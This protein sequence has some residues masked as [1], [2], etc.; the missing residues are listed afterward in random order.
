MRLVPESVKVALNRMRECSREYA[1]VAGR[2]GKGI[3]VM[4]PLCLVRTEA[5]LQAVATRLLGLAVRLEVVA[6]EEG[7]RVSRLVSAGAGDVA[8]AV[9]TGLADLGDEARR[10]VGDLQDQPGELN[11]AAA[12]VHVLSGSVDDVVQEWRTLETFARLDPNYASLDPAGA[13]V[14]RQQ[15]TAMALNL[16]SLTPAWALVD[17]GGSGRAAERFVD[18][19]IDGHDLARGDRTRWAGHMGMA[20]AVTLLTGAIGGEGTATADTVAHEVTPARVV[21]TGVERV[22]D[23]NRLPTDGF[24]PRGAAGDARRNRR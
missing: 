4:P 1:A 21:A 3:P 2:L 20:L 6:L 7:V 14:A 11:P 13:A 17:P 12:Q 16:A 24:E 8:G 5:D 22:G 18:R 9:R 10:L 15:V 19:A 23:L